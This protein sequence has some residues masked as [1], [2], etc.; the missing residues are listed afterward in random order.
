MVT[1]VFF[2]IANRSF[3][4]FEML[5]EAQLRNST[6]TLSQKV[7]HLINENSTDERSTNVR[8]FQTQFTRI[9]RRETQIEAGVEF[10][11]KTFLKLI[12]L[13]FWDLLTFFFLSFY[14]SNPL[15]KNQKENRNL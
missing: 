4:I 8:I 3:L 11:L 7:S 13:L 14:Q 9:C 1:A 6:G 2:D 10:V 15:L 5:K 12:F